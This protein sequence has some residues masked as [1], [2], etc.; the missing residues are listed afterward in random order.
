M[1]FPS[2][3]DIIAAVKDQRFIKDPFFAGNSVTTGALGNPIMFGGGFSQVF[4]IIKGDE[5]WAFKVWKKS[6]PKNRERYE[7]LRHYFVERNLPY[8]VEFEFVEHGL[9]VN[10]ELLPVLR[11]QWFDYPLLK[12]YINQFVDDPVVLNNLA[13]N[14]L[15]MTDTLHKNGISHGD[16]KN[17]NIF[18][19]PN[20]NIKLIDY[21]AACIPE[22]EGMPDVCLGTEG[23]QHPLRNLYGEFASTKVDHFSELII[24]LSIKAVAENP[25]LWHKYNVMAADYRLMF[26]YVDFV[27][28]RY[29]EIRRD[30]MTLSPEI[31]ALVSKLDGYL[32]AHLLLTPIN[33]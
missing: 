24:Y 7:A 18:V 13:T 19:G 28:F 25:L 23:Y 22:M 33:S 10:G 21:D 2:L 15:S 29:S 5:K 11:M 32:A 1:A 3:T 26:R 8:L 4:Q 27:E 6:I 20:G 9:L 17:D 12:H 14:F 16:L 30:L 31:Q